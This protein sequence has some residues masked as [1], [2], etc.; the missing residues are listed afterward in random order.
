M[1]DILFSAGGQDGA[2]G[3]GLLADLAMLLFDRSH[4]FDIESVLCGAKDRIGDHD[5]CGICYSPRPP[6]RQSGMM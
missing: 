4:V 5:N 1:L 2:L 3:L 6:S